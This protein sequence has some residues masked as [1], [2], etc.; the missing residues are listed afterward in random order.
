MNREICIFCPDCRGRFYV[1]KADIV[2]EDILE[3]SLCGAEIEIL[4]EVPLKV[5]IVQ[6]EY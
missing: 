2:E 3:C 1:K 5:R 4:Q 6:D